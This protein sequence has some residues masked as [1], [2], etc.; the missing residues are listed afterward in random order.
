MIISP[1]ILYLFT[2][3]MTFGIFSIVKNYYNGDVYNA[4]VVSYRSYTKQESD[5]RMKRRFDVTYNVPVFEL[6]V[7]NEKIR[8]ESSAHASSSVPIIGSVSKISYTKGGLRSQ[9]HKFS[10]YFIFFFVFVFSTFLCFTSL[11]YTRYSLGY[12]L[13]NKKAIFFIMLKTHFV[14]LQLFLLFCLYFIYIKL[15]TVSIWT[16]LS[17]ITFII[18]SIY[19]AVRRCNK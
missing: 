15:I 14:L 8:V 3:G 17:I 12:P 18:G 11:M 16:V 19:L 7:D 10:D 5:S 4:T 1:F 9:E 13:K 6:L 2:L